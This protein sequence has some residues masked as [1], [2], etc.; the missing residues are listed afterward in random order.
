MGLEQRILR[1][2]SCLDMSFSWLDWDSLQN[3]FFALVVFVG[4]PDLFV[5]VDSV[6]ETQSRF[7]VFDVLDSE[8]DPLGDDITSD[9]FVDDDTNGVLGDVVNSTSFTVVN[10][11]WHTL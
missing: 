3:G 9:S 7:G 1:R 5:V 11:V 4:F 8:V 10:F 2:L 6:Q